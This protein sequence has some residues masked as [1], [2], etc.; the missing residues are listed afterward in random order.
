MQT[1]K[2]VKHAQGVSAKSGKAYNFL[3]VSDGLASINLSL[4]P[5]S[6]AQLV[7][8]NPEP[9]DDIEVEVHV[10]DMYGNLRGT[11]VEIA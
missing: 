9:G 1:L 5:E 11:V 7:E 2:F 6:T 8:I 3:V 4:T 10:S